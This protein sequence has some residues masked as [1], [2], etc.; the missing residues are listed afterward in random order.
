MDFKSLIRK[1]NRSFQIT[2]PQSFREKFEIK[3]GDYLEIIEEDD[4]IIIQ[5]IEVKKKESVKKKEETEEKE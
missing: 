1:I 4:R 2:L 5:P 3:E